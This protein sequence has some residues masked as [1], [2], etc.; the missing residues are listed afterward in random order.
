[1]SYPTSAAWSHLVLSLYCT[2][3]GPSCDAV[4]L[5]RITTVA[6]SRSDQLDLRCTVEPNWNGLSARLLGASVTRNRAL[7]TCEPSCVPGAARPFLR[8]TWQRRSSPLEEAEPGAMGHVAASEPTSA[9]RRG[10]ELR[11]A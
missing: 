5:G 6:M 9:E 8:N 11:N 4:M 1:M 10:P 2:E 7:D 3:P